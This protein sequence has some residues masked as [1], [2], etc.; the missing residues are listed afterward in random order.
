MDVL[1]I[2]SIREEDGPIVGVNLVN[3][4]KLKQSGFPVADGIIVVP[5]Q[6]K[7]KTILEHYQLK[8]REIFEQ[9]IY[10]I[11]GE[12]AQIPV[13]ESLVKALS[14]KNINPSKIWFELL[15]S[16]I[17]EIRSKIWREG[18]SKDLIKK[19]NPQP[20]FFTQEI[21]ASGQAHFDQQK[22]IAVIKLFS[23]KLSINQ[24]LELEEIIQKADRKLYIPQLYQWL[25]DGGIKIVKVSPYTP[26]LNKIP[27]L[28]LSA[29]AN[30][31]EIIKHDKVSLKVF[32]ELGADMRNENDIQ[33]VLVN[34]EKIT[35]FDLK[36]AQ[37]IE[38]A[39]SIG[40]NPLIYKLPDLIDSSGGIRGSLRL[41]HDQKLLKM[42]TEAVLFARN[43]KKLN[44]ISIAVPFVRSV[45]EF[46]QIKRELAS[47]GISRK[48]SLSLWL[49]LA[50]PE[51]I[52]HIQ[53]YVLAGFDGAILNLDEMAAWLGG[54]DPSQPESI[55][56]KKQISATL[57]L[58]KDSLNFLTK[59]KIPV[60]CSGNLSLHDEVL[61]FLIEYGI[62]GI[63]V[64]FS[65][66]ASAHQYLREMEKRH[67][68]A[69]FN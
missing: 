19:L 55:F 11:K 35:D 5:P 61:S 9:S 6:I 38:A 51:N 34:S 42:E 49:E 28:D 21:L 18:F 33:G 68:R 59:A 52:F 14:S 31:D 23:G 37:L 4:A 62:W 43:K 22:K 40:E 29:K 66:V 65:A 36:V 10:L 8:D 12:I 25:I 15:Q 57:D 44:N 2:K 24:E 30:F 60:I 17:N 58:I 67:I 39:T 3:L 56:Y 1:P 45:Q 46:L 7:L 64:D 16:W 20:V 26:I 41:I 63:A 53:E 27:D 50:V 69:K 48:P 32:L 13:P 54:F 47:F